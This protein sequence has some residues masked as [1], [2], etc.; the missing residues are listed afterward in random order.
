MHDDPT[1][2]ATLI[3]PSDTARTESVMPDAPVQGNLARNSEA[4]GTLH[5]LLDELARR[6]EPVMA[7]D[8]GDF[9]IAMDERRQLCAVADAVALRANLL[10]AHLEVIDPNDEVLLRQGDE[11]VT[12]YAGAPL[13]AIEPTE[14]VVA[15][16]PGDDT[17]PG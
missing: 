5:D 4:L 16:P 9:G 6:L 10:R 15:E 17:E 2:Q 1:R 14:P 7:N 12:F 11:F 8:R 3:G 13:H